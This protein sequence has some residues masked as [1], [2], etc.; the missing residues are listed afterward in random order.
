[1]KMLYT[2]L[3]E[4]KEIK[5]YPF[6]F[7]PLMIVCFVL[8]LALCGLCFGLTT[9]RFIAFLQGE[10]DVYGWIQ[11]VLLYVFSL[12][13]AALALSILIRTQYILTED[14]LI[15]QFGF[16]RSK[17]EIS[18]IVSVHLFKGMNKL[19][20][21]FD[22]FKTKYMV[23]VVKEAWYDDFVQ[24][25]LARKPSIGFSFTSPEEEEEFKKKK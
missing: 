17:Y 25:L 24:T 11:F 13:G 20:V 7:S 12:L 9:P 18:S 3:M 1:M 2:V 4:D 23:I 5:R 14:R 19:T 15:L 16:I 10:Q 6:K 21:Y 22:D 8:A